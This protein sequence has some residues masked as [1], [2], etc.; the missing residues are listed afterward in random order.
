MQEESGKCTLVQ[1]R[2]LLVVLETASVFLVDV[3]GHSSVL[4]AVGLCVFHKIGELCFLGQ[5]GRIRHVWIRA[6]AT[7]VCCHWH[8]LSVA[9]SLW[10]N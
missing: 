6:F 9:T 10:K 3:Q 5:D 1:F 4:V 2:P 8:S 7:D